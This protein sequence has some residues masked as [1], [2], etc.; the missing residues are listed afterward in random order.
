MLAYGTTRRRWDITRYV[1]PPVHPCKRSISREKKEMCRIRFL[2]IVH[3]R[4]LFILL[5]HPVVFSSSH[6]AP[7]RGCSLYKSCTRWSCVFMHANSIPYQGSRFAPLPV[8]PERS[9]PIRPPS[10]TFAFQSSLIEDLPFLIGDPIAVDK[11]IRRT[12]L[13]LIKAFSL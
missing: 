5:W 6:P 8:I 9:P 3:D 12:R 7:L 13:R 4:W 1:P 11:V 10:E 2:R